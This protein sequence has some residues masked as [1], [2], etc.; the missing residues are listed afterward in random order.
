MDEMVPGGRFREAVFEGPSRIPVQLGGL[1]NSLTH[2]RDKCR[3][4]GAAFHAGIFCKQMFY[5]L[6]T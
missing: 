4:T 6:F 2:A 5:F 1:V 3:S